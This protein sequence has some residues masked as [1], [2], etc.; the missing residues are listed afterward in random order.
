MLQATEFTY[1]GVY[2]G[3]YG[4][5]IATLDGSYMDETAYATP[6]ITTAKSPNQKRFYYTDSQ[7]ES[8]PTFNFS[9]ISPTPIPDG[10]QREIMAWLDN[11]RGFR[12]LIFMQPGLDQYTYNCVITIAGIHYHAGNVIGYNL[13]ILFD[14]P[15]HLKAT[16]NVI[17]T[18]DGA[19][20]KE[21]RLHNGSD[22]RDDYVYPVVTFTS[23]G[24]F[25]SDGG[26]ANCNIEIINTTDD[27]ERRFVFA[28]LDTGGGVTL[29]VDNERKL[30]TGNKGDFYLENFVDK[31]WLRLRHGVN[32]VTVRVNGQATFSYP[33]YAKIRF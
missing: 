30:I 5:K 20:P 4:L 12:P 32:Y 22:I 18:S 11:R 16:R 15:Y 29:T 9:I 33:E 8:P 2:S 31:K 1:D 24:T 27:K 21:V 23:N 13:S 7:Y 3:L 28:G 19:A 17:V 14:S 6:N 26:V 25:T 10:V